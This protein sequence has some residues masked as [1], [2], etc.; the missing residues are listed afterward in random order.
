MR[1]FFGAH[2]ENHFVEIVAAA[3]FYSAACEFL[4]YT[5]LKSDVRTY[6][7]LGMARVLLGYVF[8]VYGHRFFG[9]ADAHKI[10]FGFLKGVFLINC[11]L[12]LSDLMS[13][14]PV[15][16]VVLLAVVFFPKW[17]FICV[18]IID[19]ARLATFNTVYDFIFSIDEH[20]L[21]HMEV[22]RNRRPL[23]NFPRI[24]FK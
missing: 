23:V 22:L 6:A 3:V 17:M 12:F 18:L 10:Q 19:G 11:S 8:E 24:N 1:E 13:H 9:D 21:Y 7:V 2:S 4:A 15:S 16:W 20:C 14:N 5:F